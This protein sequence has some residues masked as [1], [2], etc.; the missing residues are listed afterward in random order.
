MSSAQLQ[1]SSTTRSVS[2]PVSPSQ[3]A[4]LDSQLREWQA[5]GMVDESAASAIRG[6]YVAVRRVTLVRVVL[7]LGAA[8][9]AIGLIWLVAANLDRFAPL[10]RFLLVAA[11]WVALTV[12]AEILAARRERAGDVASPVVGAARFLA[13]ASFA[14]VVF[15][16]AQSLQVPAYEASLLGYWALG[17][18]VYAYVVR[19]LAPLVLAVG[20]L[21]VWYVW[22]VTAS[23]QGPFGFAVAALVGAVVA[24]AVSVAH[25]A[26][27]WPESAT[28]WRESAAVVALLGM[29][30]AAI[31]R[32]TDQQSTWSLAL[33]VGMVLAV[34]LAGAAAWLGGRWDRAEVALVVGALVL[35]IGLSLWRTDDLD[36][37]RIGAA[38]YGRAALAVA[39][40]LL[41]ASGYAALGAQRDSPR[42]TVVA[43][44][45]LVVFVTFQAFAVFAPILSGSALFLTVG[46][47]LIVSGYLADRGRRRLVARV[48]GE[49]S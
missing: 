48:E 2:H 22:E 33:V 31:P 4:W 38:G 11:I 6:R 23:T 39:A 18:L 25:R 45:A 41:V 43:T 5:E 30:V 9:V 12:V 26:R 8:F 3:L 46:V 29:F 19:D 44:V 27:W 21:A 20:G 24:T 15:Q 14:A 36:T 35:G 49:Q 32:G 16:A 1:P 34:V 37:A 13:A 28:P 10:A 40:Y 17:A 7:S 42:L 47:I